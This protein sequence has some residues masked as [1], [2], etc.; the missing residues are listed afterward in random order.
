MAGSAIL[1]FGLAMHGSSSNYRRNYDERYRQLCPTDCPLETLPSDVRE[2]YSTARN[3]W[4]VALASYVV[5]GAAFSLGLAW[6]LIAPS[7]PATPAAPGVELSAGHMRFTPIAGP[8][9]LGGTWQVQ[10]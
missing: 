3:Q 2:M 1:V 6:L 5:G 9:V 7:G 4:R 10:F 8:H